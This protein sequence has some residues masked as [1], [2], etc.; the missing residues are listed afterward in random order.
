MQI[1]NPIQL[2][3]ERIFLAK[4]KRLSV[5]MVLII[6]LITITPLCGF[7]FQCGCDWPWFGLDEK[8]NIY[9]TNSRNQ[10]PWCVSMPMGIFST[11]VA[12]IS[13]VIISIASFGG[14]SK[15]SVSRQVLIRTIS[16]L[17]V[18]V[19]VASLMAVF[20]VLLK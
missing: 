10:C 11:L 20:V 6:A 8:C 12:I 5:I 9:Q 3:L 13:G 7:L 18:F 17:I 1:L 15:Q 4:E 14:I 19:C 2:Q 16:G